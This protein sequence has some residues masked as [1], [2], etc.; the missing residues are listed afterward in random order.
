MFPDKS[1]VLF[2]LSG[3]C[4]KSEITTL[5]VPGRLVGYMPQDLALY[6]E[7]TVEETVYF[8]SLLARMNRPRFEQRMEF[9][10]HLLDILNL[11]RRLVGK[12]A[13]FD[14]KIATPTNNKIPNTI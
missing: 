6:N 7:F 10:L 2:S 12:A 11:R 8:F 4:I 9:L 13:F 1:V 3:C 5:Q 14:E